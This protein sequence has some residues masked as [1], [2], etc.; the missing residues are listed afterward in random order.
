M[1]GHPPRLRLAWLFAAAAI[2]VIAVVLGPTIGEF[3]RGSTVAPSSPP[4][5]VR[6]C[7]T[8]VCGFDDGNLAFDYPA[9]WASAKFQVVSSF[10]TL[11]VYLSTEPLFDPCVRQTN[12]DGSSSVTCRSPVGHLGDGGVLVEWGAWGFPGWTFDRT[13]G[14]L[15]RAGGREATLE[16]QAPD[17]GCVGIG[18]VRAI[19]VVV[20]T[21]EV[22]WNWT[23]MDACLAGPDPGVAQRQI[24][25]MLA[26][27]V[28]RSGAPASTPTA[29]PG[30][31]FAIDC[32]PLA[33]EPDACARAIAFAVAGF[34]PSTGRVTLVTVEG[35]DVWPTCSSDTICRVPTI[36]VRISFD[37]AGV[38]GAL[39]GWTDVPRVR[40]TDGWIQLSQIR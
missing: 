21:P 24:E 30:P 15:I 40:T 23:Q 11:L 14:R 18:G 3:F 28:W 4:H 17:A 32:G 7:E 29:T 37:D 26:S 35:P 13:R 25:A 19:K 8:V 34:D 1:T 9:A 5:V 10:S 16:V 39:G 20:P 6:A 38:G 31:S 33:S 12:L 27:V 2:L 22:L 36:V